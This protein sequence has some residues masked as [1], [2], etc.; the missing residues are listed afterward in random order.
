MTIPRQ[1]TRA[2]L[3]LFV[4]TAMAAAVGGCGSSKT[5]SSSSSGA[6]QT[7]KTSLA[8]TRFALH[9]GLAFGAFHRYIYKPYRAGGFRPVSRHK[10]AIAKAGL[11]AAFAY[12]ETKLALNDARS[13]PLLSKLLAPLLGLQNRLSSLSTSLRGGSVNGAAIQSTSS[14]VNAVSAAGAKNGQPITD[15]PT[16][17]LG[18]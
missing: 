14:D 17:A 6:P 5:T 12:H 2:L 16:P 7:H 10:L 1:S 18:G 11:A 8:K 3:L 4:L 9:A 13:S 15:Q